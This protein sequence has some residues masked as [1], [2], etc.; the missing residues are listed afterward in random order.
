[1]PTT[2]TIQSPAAQPVVVEGP[3]LWNRWSVRLGSRCLTFDT[4]QEAERARRKAPTPAKAARRLKTPPVASE[5]AAN[6]ARQE[7]NPRMARAGV[8]S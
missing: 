7:Q 4:R 6:E 1:M 5:A 3:D 2:D 8:D